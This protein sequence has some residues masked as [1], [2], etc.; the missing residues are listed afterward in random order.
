MVERAYALLQALGILAG[1]WG[2]WRGIEW[3]RDRHKRD[4]EGSPD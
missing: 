2:G 4:D 1:A 3:A